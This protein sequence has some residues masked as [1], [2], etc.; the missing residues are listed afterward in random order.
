MLGEP[1]SWSI[2][3][4]WE[5][6]HLG[7]GGGTILPGALTSVLVHAG[8]DV[9]VINVGGGRGIEDHRPVQSRVVEE[10]KVCVLDKVIVGVPREGGQCPTGVLPGSLHLTAAKAGGKTMGRV[11]TGMGEQV[12]LTWRYPSGRGW[13]LAA[14]CGGR[15]CC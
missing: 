9:D 2:F 13:S 8:G 11:G 10:V 6:S 1:F 12:L 15:V 3:Q 7:P 4:N 5:Q 14:G